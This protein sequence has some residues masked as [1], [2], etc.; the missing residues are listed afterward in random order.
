[1]EMLHKMLPPRL[2]ALLAPDG[3][4]N[5]YKIAAAAIKLRT[6][7]VLKTAQQQLNA[8]IAKVKRGISEWEM[9]GYWYIFLYP[10]QCILNLSRSL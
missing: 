2:C 9:L 6:K 4:K 3:T 1:M 10:E 7:R 8:K 5:C